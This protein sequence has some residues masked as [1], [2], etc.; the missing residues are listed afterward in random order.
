MFSQ[1]VKQ[2][3]PNSYVDSNALDYPWT[4]AGWPV[5]LPDRKECRFE[6][7]DYFVVLNLQDML[8]QGTGG[9]IELD[10]I[11]NHFCDW[12][13]MDRV[14]VV[15][16]PQRIKYEWPDHSFKIVEFSTHQ[17]A[18]WQQYKKY[19]S[20]L[21]EAFDVKHKNFEYNY[22]CMNRHDKPHRRIVYDRLR[23]SG[24][25]G[26]CSLQSRGYELAYPNK[27][28]EDYEAE[29]DNCANLI[30]LDANFNSALFNIITESQYSEPH[31]IITEKTFNAIVAGMP[32]AVIGHQLALED[33]KCLGFATF[34]NVFDEEYDIMDNHSRI[35]AVINLH[36]KFINERMSVDDM[37]EIYEYCS[38]RIIYNR[39]YFFNNFGSDQLSSFQKQLLKIWH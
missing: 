10:T 27:P 12:A 21:R 5:R 20:Q 37:W 13:D 17:Y 35:D 38:E 15:V 9:I 32:F 3:F 19:E 7:R 24:M 2:I 30:S 36:P 33:I 31:G 29:Y 22:V 39:E 18:T 11:H 25:A 16:W 28:F 26:N 14:I 6:Q 8:T 34:D 1:I 23:A 4:S